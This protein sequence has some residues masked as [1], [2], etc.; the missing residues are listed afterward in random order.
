MTWPANSGPTRSRRPVFEAGAAPGFPTGVKW[1]TVCS[2]GSAEHQDPATHPDRLRLQI[3]RG[4]HR[5][6]HALP[7]R[8]STSTTRPSRPRM[9][10]KSLIFDGE[11]EDGAGRG[12]G[13]AAAAAVL[14]GVRAARG[15]EVIHD[16]DP[17]VAVAHERYWGRLCLTH[18]T[19]V[20]TSRPA[21]VDVAILAPP[22][23]RRGCSTRPEA[24]LRNA[25]HR[26]QIT[27]YVVEQGMQL[28]TE[29]AAARSA[30]SP[31]AGAT[32]GSRARAV[33]PGAGSRGPAGDCPQAT[34]DRRSTRLAPLPERRFR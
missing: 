25:C 16:D 10:H 2:F 17:D 7:R 11:V 6:R 24:R 30:R 4:P 9:S 8:P 29:P 21:A 27:E 23:H 26:V 34:D 22:S 14:L 33:R 3:T 28:V 5:P 32:G 12:V 18:P 13:A 1:R 20:P 31:V 15:A 19:S